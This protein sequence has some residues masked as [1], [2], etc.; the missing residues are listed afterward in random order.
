MIGEESVYTRKHIYNI[1]YR[2]RTI[3]RNAQNEDEDALGE[4][5]L[6]DEDSGSESAYGS[7]SDSDGEVNRSKRRRISSDTVSARTETVSAQPGLVSL[8]RKNVGPR[9]KLSRLGVLL[10]SSY[11]YDQIQNAVGCLASTR[12]LA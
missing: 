7:D 1:I 8:Q 3:R 10:D 6:D 5:N 2:F 11:C 9:V 4:H 12:A